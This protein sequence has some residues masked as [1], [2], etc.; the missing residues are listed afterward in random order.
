VELK[1]KSNSHKET[2][3]SNSV[4]TLA[5]EIKIVDKLGGA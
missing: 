1:R 5:E 4:M 2:R 3:N